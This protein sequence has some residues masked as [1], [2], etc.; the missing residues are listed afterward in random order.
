MAY[1]QNLRS[2]GLQA[3]SDLTSASTVNPQYLFVS[4]NTSGQIALTGAGALA[5]GVLQDAPNAQG[6]EGQVGILGVTKVQVGA[7]VTAA[8]P[9]MSNS[10]GQAIT[11][12]AGNFIRARALQTATAAGQV[13]PALLIGPYYK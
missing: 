12:T 9:L 13:I 11:A 1:D 2:I 5:D 8:D 3:A 4:V 6:V 7:A 10:S